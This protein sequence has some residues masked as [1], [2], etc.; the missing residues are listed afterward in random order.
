MK[1][2]FPWYDSVWLTNYIRAKEILAESNPQKLKQFI[3][4]I[5]PLKTRSDFEVIEVADILS[6]EI[7]EQSKELII[8]LQNREKETHEIFN[9]GRLVIHNHPFFDRIQEDLTKKVSQ[10]V[11]EEVEASYN[12]LSLYYNIGV[13]DVH[14]DSPEAKYTLDI[15]L[16]QSTDWKIHISQRMDWMEEFEYSGQDWQKHILEDPVNKF[17]SYSLKPGSG[18]IFSGSSQWHYRNPITEKSKQHFCHLIFFH[19]FPKGTKELLDPRN[20]A[21]M[22]ETPELEKISQPLTQANDSKQ[23]LL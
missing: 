13:C 19:F 12:F 6:P 15:C 18:I 14:M 17:K 22:F 16:E 10:L 11:K 4:A 1:N 20:W 5:K 9:F 2:K 23:E 8:N 21:S 3:E 7:V